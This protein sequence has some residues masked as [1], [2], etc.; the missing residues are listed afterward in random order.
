VLHQRS[1]G[2]AL[3]RRHQAQHRIQRHVRT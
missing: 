1:R 2:D 3:A